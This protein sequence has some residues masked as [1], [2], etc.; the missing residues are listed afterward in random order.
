[1]TAVRGP[2]ESPHEALEKMPLG[3][4]K[5]TVVYEVDFSHTYSAQGNDLGMLPPHGIDSRIPSTDS[6]IKNFHEFNTN[7]DAEFTIGADYRNHPFPNDAAKQQAAEARRSKTALTEM[8]GTPIGF[9]RDTLY[10]YNSVCVRLKGVKGRW[11]EI[12]AE[13]TQ[14]NQKICVTDWERED[15]SDNP[16]DPACGLGK[17]ITCRDNPVEA[18]TAFKSD[19]NVMPIQ[20]FCQE[21]CDDPSFEFYWRVV[22]SQLPAKFEDID[23]D[24]DK[25]D[26]VWVQP[27]GENWC[28]MR[29]E[30]DFPSSLY[31][32]YPENYEEPPVFEAI[33]QSSASTLQ[34]SF[35]MLAIALFVSCMYL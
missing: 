10:E 14:P 29:A 13:T 24:E 19:D 2:Y 17:L 21:S 20:F 26:Q 4:K 8:S 30:D 1:M 7:N 3:M 5:C 23:D 18:T 22:V 34:V 35:A 15:M 25:N 32:P 11:V 6:R 12:M 31:E 27:D 28:G 33:I 9:K 16:Y